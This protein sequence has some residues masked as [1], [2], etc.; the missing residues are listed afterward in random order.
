MSTPP[1]YNPENR[2]KPEIGGYAPYETVLTRGMEKEA[3]AKIGEKGDWRPVPAFAMP[4]PPNTV[5][6]SNELFEKMYYGSH[7][8]AGGGGEVKKPSSYG[9]PTPM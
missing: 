3:T 8:G 5:T 1:Q 6:I 9:N 4:Q 7:N 2:F